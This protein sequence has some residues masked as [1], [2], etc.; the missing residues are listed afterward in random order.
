MTRIRARP[1]ST[2]VTTDTQECC[3]KLKSCPRY[4]GRPP[5]SGLRR[6]GSARRAGHGQPDR[7]AA[8][9]RCRG[10]RRPTQAVT[11][12][13]TGRA[14]EAVPAIGPALRASTELAR[15]EALLRAADAG[16][17]ARRGRVGLGQQAAVVGDRQRAVPAVAAHAIVSASP[18]RRASVRESILVLFIGVR[19]AVG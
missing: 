16:V 12:V 3:P 6:F 10:A 9:P 13:G 7:A 11:A 1:S 19:T 14:A 17:A 5:L 2:V 8:R 18:V 15:L 4:S